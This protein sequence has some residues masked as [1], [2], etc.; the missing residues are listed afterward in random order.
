MRSI[1]NGTLLAHNLFI[2]IKAHPGI[3]HVMQS[4]INGTLLAHNPTI[5]VQAK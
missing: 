3:H 5:V 1:I 4:I 2:I